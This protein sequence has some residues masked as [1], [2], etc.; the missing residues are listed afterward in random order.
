MPQE[1]DVR[2]IIDRLL[3]EADWDIEDKA[4]LSTEEAAAD[5]RADY[6]LKDSRTG[7]L[8]VIEAKRFS[9]DPYSAKDQARDYAQSLPVHFVILSNGQDHYY[10]DYAEGDARPILGMPP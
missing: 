6:L 3:R 8:A 2:I 9:I 1:S 4:Q 5:G 10:W 7:P